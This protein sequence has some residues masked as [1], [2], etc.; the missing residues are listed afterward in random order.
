MLL[1]AIARGVAGQAI[2]LMRRHLDHIERGL[3]LNGPTEHDID[4]NA[5]FSN[6]RVR[7]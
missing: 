2:K 6:L 7:P 1:D 3:D 4:L 5:V